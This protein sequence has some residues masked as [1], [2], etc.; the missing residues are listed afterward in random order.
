[1]PQPK[2]LDPSAYAADGSAQVTQVGGPV[3]ALLIHG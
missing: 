2:H 1:M 3:G